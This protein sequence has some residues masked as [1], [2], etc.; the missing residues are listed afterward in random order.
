M[1][2]PATEIDIPRMLAMGR[3]FVAMSPHSFMGEFNPEAVVRMFRFMIDTPT[4][5]L[6][7]SDDGMIG[8]TLAPVFFS[9]GALM[10]EE[11]FLWARG[12]GRSLVRAFEARAK[13]MGATFSYVSTLENEK[14]EKATKF[15]G[16][17]GYRMIE[18]RYVK[19]L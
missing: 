13:E 7:V 17:L 9:P 5:L 10:A 12:S 11:N 16:L 3:E 8:G 2:R 6:L 15:M 1:I 18:R 4:C 19:E 14:A